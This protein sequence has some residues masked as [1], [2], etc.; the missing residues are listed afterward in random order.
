MCFGLLSFKSDN[1]RQWK[2][3]QKGN[4]VSVDKL[5]KVYQV[6]NKEL[7]KLNNKGEVLKTYSVLNSGA[8]SSIDTRNALQTLLF[9]KDQQEAVVLDNMLGEANT[10]NFTKYFEWVDLVCFSNRDNAFWLYS[11]TNQ[12][13]VK[14]DKNLN[15]ISRYPNLAQTLSI[16]IQPIQLF[17]ANETVYLFDKKNGLIQFDVFGN[18]KRKIK[19]KGAE[20]VQI[21]GDI[22]YYQED[23]TIKYYNTKSFEKGLLTETTYTIIDFCVFKSSLYIQGEEFLENYSI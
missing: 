23:N 22:V 18:Y 12:E 5:G 20:K 10:I 16:D 3:E 19:L 4:L 15:V 1:T 14:T 2:I 13:L 17:E 7:V 9:F 21:V 6:T 11:V 8:I